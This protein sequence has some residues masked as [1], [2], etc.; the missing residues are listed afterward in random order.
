MRS[1]ALIRS[2]SMALYLFMSAH[3]SRCGEA[4]MDSSR[5]ESFGGYSVPFLSIKIIMQES[6]PH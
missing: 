5:A 4:S 2:N 6:D 1:L 3:S